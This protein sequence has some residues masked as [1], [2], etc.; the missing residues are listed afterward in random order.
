MLAM[1][2]AVEEVLEEIGAGEQPTILVLN[3]ADALTDER[4][5]ELGFRHPDAVLV[6]AATGEG[7]DELSARI[8]REFE[9]SF[10]P[11]ELLLPYSEGGRLAELHE[12][13][14]ELDR[15]DTQEGVRVRVRL[16]ASVAERFAPYV[17]ANGDGA[18]NGH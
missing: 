1:I 2:S 8:E 11:F 14:G 4:R 9:R 17:V 16:P 3:K 12:A 6:S 5:R 15:E 10:K 18:P 13:A 7:I